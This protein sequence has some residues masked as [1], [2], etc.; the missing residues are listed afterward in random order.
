MYVAGLLGVRSWLRKCFELGKALRADKCQ[1][2]KSVIR[3]FLNLSWSQ[4]DSSTGNRIQMDGLEPA[5]PSPGTKPPSSP[6]PPWGGQSPSIRGGSLLPGFPQIS[7][8]H[9]PPIP[10]SPREVRPA[11]W[12]VVT[13]KLNLGPWG[14]V[15]GGA[16]PRLLWKAERAHRTTISRSI[17]QSLTSICGLRLVFVSPHFVFFFVMNGYC[18]A[19]LEEAIGRRWGPG[20]R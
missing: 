17:C 9:T 3:S 6:R 20:Q 18:Q 4:S 16:Q 14:C 5:S 11:P 12:T 7:S 1:V 2:S 13:S 8:M 19:G 15:T 10:M